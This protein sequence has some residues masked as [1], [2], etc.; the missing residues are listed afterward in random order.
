MN[1]DRLH[2]AEA[3]F[4]GRYPGGFQDPELVAVRKR[5]NVDRLSDLARECFP[6]SRFVRPGAVLDDV[7]RVVGRSSMVS[8]FEKPKFRDFVAGLDA[9]DRDR[10]GAALKQRL[11]GRGGSPRKGFEAMVDLLLEARLA[12]WSLISAIPYYFHP[13]REV[14]MK[15]TT[16]KGVVSTFELDV[17]P[18]RAC[19]YWE[20]YAAYR[21]QILAMRAQVSPELAPN[22]AAFCG[23]L[24]MSLDRRS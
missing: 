7:V 8:M 4:F 3:A 12:K 20:F 1:L 18:Y 23:F 24:M 19:P 17:P 10:L 6:K 9:D 22:N 5:H 15:P 13:Q 16:V 2:D 11:H 14:F 21:E